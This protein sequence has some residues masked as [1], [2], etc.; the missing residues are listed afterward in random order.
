MELLEGRT[1]RDCIQRVP[2][3]LDQF[4]ELATGIADGLQAAHTRSIIHR[5]IKPANIFVT[6]R[7]SA[8]ILDFGLAKLSNEFHSGDGHGGEGSTILSEAHLTSPGTAIG[9]IAYM[10]PEQASGHALDARTDLFSFGAVLYEMAT[11]RTAFPGTTAAMVFDAILHKAPVA[12][13][14]LNPDVPQQLEQLINKALEKERSLRYQS[15][16]EMAVDLKRLCREVDSGKLRATQEKVSTS[17]LSSMQ[18]PTQGLPIGKIIGITVAVVCLAA[19]LGYML[20]PSF[21]PPRVTGYTQIMH[22]GLQKAFH[23]QTGAM[24][25]T[26]G[27]RL[28]VQEYLDGRYIVAQ[29]S[30]LGGDTIPIPIPL[31]NVALNN[32]SPNKSELVVG[33]FTG[34]EIEQPLW[35]VPPMGGA[36][37]RLLD[38][39]ALDGTWLPSGEFVVAHANKIS[40]VGQN[41]SL[42]R[43][44]VDFGE[45]NIFAF[46]LRISP[47]GGL[48]RFTLANMQGNSSLAQISVEGANYHRLFANQLPGDA[49]GGGNWTPDGRYF[50]FRVLH[51]G[52]HDIG[53]VRERGDLF[54]K[55][56]GKPIQLTA[57]PLSF[58][59]PQPSADGKKI[60]AIGEQ[61]RS[62]LVRYDAKSGQFLPYFGGISARSV[63]FSRDA[64]WVAYVSYPEGTLWR[65]SANGSDKLQLTSAT[66]MVVNSASWSPDGSQIAISGSETD[67]VDRIYLVP[68][69]G[70]VA[71]PVTAGELND[72]W[73]SWAP[74]GNSITYYELSGSG[75]HS[76]VKTVDVRTLKVSPVPDSEDLM[77]PERSPDGRYLVASSIAGDKMRLLDFNS[78]RWSN[79]VTMNVGHTVWS[80]DG[81]YVYF[82]SGSGPEAAIYRVA[83]PDGKAER[84][85]SL[86]GFRNA[87]TTSRPWMGSTPENAPLLMRDTGSQE[88]YALDFDA[89]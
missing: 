4:L 19:I 63:T 51:N 83:V 87:V 45:K 22:D 24:V 7:G 41:G 12:P 46:W 48:L 73:P 84:I 67:K 8:K 16:S 37:R 13:V 54:H 28:Y 65:C 35:A 74:D 77:Q 29:V 89:P 42:G 64:K 62:E 59:S 78:Q 21:P 68:A 76:T 2:I 3:P 57:G 71:K 1:L 14:T 10:S 23:V 49:P 86:E 47:D 15:A 11:G 44:L 66:T 31:P 88:V 36:P 72:Q 61:A 56:D 6:P 25:L 79:L 75:G 82:G 80:A 50:I 32:I 38:I 85:A 9:T 5:D 34:T 43:D 26:D 18:P 20:R 60:Y 40:V 17:E 39:P 69:V 30:A 52:R 70:G 53:A 27:A 55:F 33:S 81:H 58:Q